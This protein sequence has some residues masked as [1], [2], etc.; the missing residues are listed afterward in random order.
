ML[1]WGS[2]ST[3]G[4]AESDASSSNSNS[5]SISLPGRSDGAGTYLIYSILVIRLTSLDHVTDVCSYR[6]DYVGCDNYALHCCIT[7]LGSG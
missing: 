1:A 6:R 2:S 3:A 4:G 7:G 5:I